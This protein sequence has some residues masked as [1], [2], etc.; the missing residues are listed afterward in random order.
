MTLDDQY[1]KPVGVYIVAWHV[2]ELCGCVEAR[3]TLSA[4][5]HCLHVMVCASLPCFRNSRFPCLPVERMV[6]LC[7]NSANQT[8]W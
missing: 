7:Q 1:H 2:Q 8:V 5:L 3:R 6:W 4:F